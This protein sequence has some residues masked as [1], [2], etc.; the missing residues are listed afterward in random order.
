MKF[1]V[2]S[3]FQNVDGF[4]KGIPIQCF[5]ERHSAHDIAMEFDSNKVI[6]LSN[7]SGLFIQ[8]KPKRSIKNIFKKRG[9]KK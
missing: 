8:K 9:T 2:Y 1:T 6:I 5:P 4:E 3:S 7:Q